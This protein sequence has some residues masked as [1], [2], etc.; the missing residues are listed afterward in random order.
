MCE[1]FVDSLETKPD[2][3]MMKNPTGNHQGSA[4][5]SP[6]ALSTGSMLASAQT[7]CRS[8]YQAYESCCVD[9]ALKTVS[10]IWRPNSSFPKIFWR[11]FVKQKVIFEFN[12]VI[13]AWFAFTWRWMLFSGIFLPFRTEMSALCLCHSISW[14]QTSC[15]TLTDSGL[16]EDE[17]CLGSY[18]HLV[19]TK[20]WASG[21][22]SM[23][24]C[25]T[26]WL[27]GRKEYV[28]YGR[29]WIWGN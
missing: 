28:A 2:Y 22:E 24:G 27:P 3:E 26:M 16:S 21:L 10:T 4:C 23:Q 11:L 29:M 9:R 17:S 6:R 19:L 1:T 15:S 5:W 8:E 20:L 13:P 7:I 12:A 14:K 25:V 18:L